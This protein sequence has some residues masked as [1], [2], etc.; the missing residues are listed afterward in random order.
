MPSKYIR[1]RQ[2]HLEKNRWKVSDGDAHL[3]SPQ[4]DGLLQSMAVDVYRPGKPTK[5]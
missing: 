5:L 4:F 1:R 3:Q 2:R